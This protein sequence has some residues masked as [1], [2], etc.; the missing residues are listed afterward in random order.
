MTDAPT[1]EMDTAPIDATTEEVTWRADLPEDIRENPTIGKYDSVEKLASA[2]INLQSH[3]GRDKIAKPVTEDDWNDTYDFLGRPESADAYE[4]NINEEYP[5]QVKAAFDEQSLTAYK[6]KA[7]ELGLNANQTQ[8]LLNFYGG[9]LAGQYAAMEEAQ[10]Q[11]LEEGE[12]ALQA[13]WGRAYEQNKGFAQKAF[14]Q[15]G[16]E[17]L[18]QVMETSGLGN[19]PAVLKAFANIAKSTMADKELVGPTNQSGQALTPQE[20]KDQAA[21]LMANPAYTNKRH[22]EHAGLV[23]Q[24]QRLF[25]SAYGE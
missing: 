11:S 12:K 17:E 22:P 25:E 15:Y 7:Y 14:E 24:V 18:A 8:E 16:G 20:A 13:E 19:H 5:D 10:G 6:A 21:Q 9:N 3:L 4:I 1:A 23:K 2:H